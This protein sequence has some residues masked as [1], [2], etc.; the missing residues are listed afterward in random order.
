MKRLLT[1]AML[2]ALLTGVA[3]AALAA[4]GA[5]IYKSKCLAC[6]G[7]DGKGT[8]MAPGF[9]D[10]AFM[11]DSAED[12]ISKTI[13]DGRSGAEKKYKNFAL[14]MPPQNLEDAE[15]KAVVSYLKSLASK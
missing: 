4:D 13:Q 7:A 14:A 6:H 1:G 10:N 9:Q 12:V 8:A 2:F 15:I 5:S 11:K 3:G